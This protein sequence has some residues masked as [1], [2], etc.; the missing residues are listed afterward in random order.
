MQIHTKLV[1]YCKYLKKFI[2]K[3]RVSYERSKLSAIDYKVS[4]QGGGSLMRKLLG[5]LCA[6]ASLYADECLIDKTD[7]YI[8][9]YARC[10]DYNIL[11]LK[12]IIFNPQ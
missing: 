6:T 4:W 1:I 9:E 11:N 5:K 3:Y 2:S 12:N 8:N 7:V 10:R